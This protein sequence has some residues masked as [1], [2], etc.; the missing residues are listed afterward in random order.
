MTERPFARLIAKVR[1]IIRLNVENY[2]LMFA[3]N[4]TEGIAA[5][6]L[7]AIMLFFGL[8]V[9]FFIAVALCVLLA[10]AVGWFWAPLIIAGAFLLLFVIIVLLR[11]ILIVNPVA[12]YITRKIYK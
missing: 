7:G 6:I 11:N 1:N 10:G 3:E 2:K 4:L 8:I 9:F 12:R 5:A